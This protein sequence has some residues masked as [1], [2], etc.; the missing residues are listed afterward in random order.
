M[1][2]HRGILSNIDSISSYVESGGKINQVFEDGSTLL[3]AAVLAGNVAGVKHLLEL[4]ADP[5][6]DTGSSDLG[7][8]LAAALRL[9]QV[10]LCDILLSHGAQIDVVNDISHHI[11]QA[12]EEGSYP[13]VSKF[14]KYGL[15]PHIKFSGTNYNEPILIYAVRNKLHD[16]V[17]LLILLG[18]QVT[19]TDHHAETCLYYA[20]INEDYEMVSATLARSADPNVSDCVG[21][22]LMVHVIR[23]CNSAIVEVLAD[24]GCNLELMDLHGNQGN[25]LQVCLRSD[26]PHML[27]KLVQLGAN[28]NHVNRQHESV[29]DTCLE[30]MFD[31]RYDNATCR[32]LFQYLIRH[33]ADISRMRSYP[34]ITPEFFSHGSTKLLKLLIDYGLLIKIEHDVSPNELP[35]HLALDNS[36]PGFIE[37]LIC[38]HNLSLEMRDQRGCTAFFLAGENLQLPQMQKLYCLGANVNVSN[39][40]RVTSLQRTI[41]PDVMSHCFQWLILVCNIQVI[42]QTLSSVVSTRHAIYELYIVKYIALVYS[43]NPVD[44]IEIT[45]MLHQLNSNPLFQSCV[46]EISKARTVTRDGIPFYELF[47]INDSSLIARNKKVQKVDVRAPLSVLALLLK[48]KPRTDT[49]SVQDG[50]HPLGLAILR[51]DTTT[52]D[53]L[54]ASHAGVDFAPDPTIGPA[55]RW[56][57]IYH[58]I[59]VLHVLIYF[60]ANL[61]YIDYH[62]IG[63]VNTCIQYTCQTNDSVRIFK[64]D[65]VLQ[66]SLDNGAPLYDVHMKSLVPLYPLSTLA[67]ILEYVTSHSEV[68]EF[69]FVVVSLLHQLPKERAYCFIKFF[70][71]HFSTE[72]CDKC[73]CC[74]VDVITSLKVL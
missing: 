17:D 61:H 38:T 63:L 37:S 47:F 51:T 7:G 54:L 31:R 25:S 57:V 60:K 73:E 46:E 42:L 56:A 49:V 58:H 32:I 33:G 68:Q 23:T 6:V 18:A 26:Q 34:Y 53:M 28:V 16:L 65:M 66:A 30:C 11:H 72:T 20:I 2:L 19:D 70:A 71:L 69:Q 50:S 10:D 40:A 36:N 8:P 12:L 45:G 41:L 15:N 4:D 29:L 43:R 67:I 5:N 44:S 9:G 48:H 13:I 74:I 1:A 55:I 59:E 27:M 22:F 64:I 24:F 14:L 52:T 3:F 39:S 62:G 35:L 21:I